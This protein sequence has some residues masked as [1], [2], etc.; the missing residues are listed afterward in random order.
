MFR[1]V[2]LAGVSLAILGCSENEPKWKLPDPNH[3]VLNYPVQTIYQIDSHRSFRLV[4][5][6]SFKCVG[7]VYYF[8]SQQGIKTRVVDDVS[9]QSG[10]NPP[11]G[12]LLM[13]DSSIPVIP[14]SRSRPHSKSFQ[15]LSYS[16]DQGRTFKVMRERNDNFFNDIRVTGAILYR[17]DSGFTSKAEPDP[18]DFIDEIYANAADGAFGRI[19]QAQADDVDALK[20]QPPSV[21]PIKPPSNLRLDLTAKPK[22]RDGDPLSLGYLMPRVQTPSG[23]TRLH[24]SL[25]AQ[26]LAKPIEYSERDPPL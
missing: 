3:L 8:D 12:G 20:E 26:P 9:F 16:M 2:V 19:W 13:I 10:S 23:D 17:G 14:W 21:P 7:S 1:S 5:T 25:D 22:Y 4:P 18:P 6:G 11:Y 15:Y 24:C